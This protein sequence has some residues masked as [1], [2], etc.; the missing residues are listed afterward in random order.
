MA[1][2]GQTSQ[3]SDREKKR[4]QKQKE[5]DEKRE[6]RK[7]TSAKGKGLDYAVAYL[8]HNGR[9]TDTPPDPKLKVEIN[10]EDIQ[11]GPQTFRKADVQEERSGRIA[12]YNDDKRFGFI[13]DN[14]TQ[15]KIFFHVSG[16]TYEVKEGDLVNYEISSGPK[17]LS[18]FKIV[19]IK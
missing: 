7:A 16:T 19:K 5:K 14:Q 1:K 15:E 3:K 10:A 11:L 9:L 6:Q 2:S 17:G 8:D 4:K 13:K 18:A 12:I